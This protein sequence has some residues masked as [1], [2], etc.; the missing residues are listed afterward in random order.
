MKIIT[1]TIIKL[2]YRNEVSEFSNIW[3]MK[4]VEVGA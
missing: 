1:G 2:D 3:E 4:V